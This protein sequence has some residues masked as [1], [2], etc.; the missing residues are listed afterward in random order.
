MPSST[1]LIAGMLFTGTINTLLN[2]FQ[3]MQCV[4]HCDD[5][6]KREFFEQPIWQVRAAFITITHKG[7]RLLICLLERLSVF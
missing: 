7:N 1:V 3:D 2:K 5:P 6:L 4:K